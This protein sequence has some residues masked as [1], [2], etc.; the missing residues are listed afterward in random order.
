MGSTKTKEMPAMELHQAIYERRAV[1]EYGPAAIDTDVLNKLIDAAIQAPTALNQQPWTFTVV[2]D[3]RKLDAL[4]SQAK[5]HMLAEHGEL[6]RSAH[7]LMLS[8]PHFQ[9]FYHAP[10]LILISATAALPWCVEDCA[11]AAQNLM[12][13]AYAEGLGSCWIGF[14]QEYLNTPSGK[15]LLRLPP[16]CIPVA[17]II[18][19]LGRGPAQPVARKKAD[20]SWIG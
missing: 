19:G 16:S 12:L 6:A 4:S 9:I 20:V 1:R 7:F 15:A 18:V 5:V 11:L 13:T 3:Q 14:A 17:P 10:V 8:D 2:R